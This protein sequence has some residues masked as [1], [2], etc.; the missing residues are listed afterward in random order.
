MRHLFSV[1]Y[2]ELLKTA[3]RPNR[4]F[5]ILNKN[6]VRSYLDDIILK[7]R[8][9]GCSWVPYDSEQKFGKKVYRTYGDYIQHQK[10]KLKKSKFIGGINWLHS[11][12]ITFREVLR[13][14]LEKLHFLRCGMA[15]LC[16]GARTGSEVKA[17]HD[18]G[19]FAV[20]IDLNPGENNRYVLHGDFHDI[21]FPSNSVDIVFTNSLDHAANIERLID[22]VKR[23]LKSNGLLIIEAG[24]GSNEGRTPGHYESFWWSKINDLISLFEDSQFTLVN[25]TTLSYPWDG[26]QLC[27]KKEN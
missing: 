12:D 8:Y 15:V 5:R 1:L 18:I 27:L 4:I 7:L 20:G 23:V 3:K 19:C 17:F 2:K 22:E 13:E 14:R 24:R 9:G 26:E 11:Y 6:T 10:S 21:Q 25:R 16:L